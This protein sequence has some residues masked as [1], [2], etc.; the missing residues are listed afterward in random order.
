MTKV[1]QGLLEHVNKQDA[2]LQL[3]KTQ[4][5]E[6]AENDSEVAAAFGAKK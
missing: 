5:A 1:L 3:L 2:E 4:M 6:L